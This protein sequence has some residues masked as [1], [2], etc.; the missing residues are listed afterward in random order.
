MKTGLIIKAR[1]IR[2]D[3]PLTAVEAVIFGHR[4]ISMLWGN[5]AYYMKLSGEGLSRCGVIRS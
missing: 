4:T 1:D 5:T 3:G 2:T